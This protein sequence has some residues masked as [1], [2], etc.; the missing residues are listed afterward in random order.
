MDDDDAAV[1]AA[2]TP[3]QPLGHCFSGVSSKFADV[4][5]LDTIRRSNTR[6]DDDDDMKRRSVF[7]F[8]WIGG[9]CNDVVSQHFGGS[10]DHIARP[11]ENNEYYARDAV[12]TA[13][14]KVKRLGSDSAGSRTVSFVVRA[15]RRG[16]RGHGCE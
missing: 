1:A 7:T 12:V 3:A 16:L 10:E 15:P 13:Q 2:T 5:R 14:E 11:A 6:S 9:G 8:V 4:L